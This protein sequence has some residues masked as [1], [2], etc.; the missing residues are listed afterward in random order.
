MSITEI[1]LV[2]AFVFMVADSALFWRKIRAIDMSLEK[3]IMD[4]IRADKENDEARKE[5]ARLKAENN[6][7]FSAVLMAE[8][9]EKEFTAEFEVIKDLMKEDR[10]FKLTDELKKHNRM[11]QIK[12]FILALMSNQK[13]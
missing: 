1:I 7:L 3:C 2:S 8:S 13:P 5:I 10:H 9:V 11:K 12:A 4:T 6:A